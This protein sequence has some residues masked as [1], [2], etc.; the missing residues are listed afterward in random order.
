MREVQQIRAD[1]LTDL[2][3]KSARSGKI[4]ILDDGHTPFPERFV[5]FVQ[6]GNGKGRVRFLGRLKIPFHPD[7]H[8]LRAALE[9]A[10]SAGAQDRWLLDLFHLQDRPIEISRHAFASFRRRDLNVIDAR[11]S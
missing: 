6:M 7:V 1:F 3:R 10:T 9:P 11:H 4:I 2:P 8:L 5:E